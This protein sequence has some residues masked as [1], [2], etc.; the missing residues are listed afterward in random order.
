MS[1]WSLFYGAVVSNL[2]HVEDP[3]ELWEV[4]AG[5]LGDVWDLRTQPY[6][7]DADGNVYDDIHQV[8][9]CQACDQS[10]RS[11]SHALVLVDNPQQRCVAHQTHH[12]HHTRD[13]GVD[14]LDGI[15]NGRAFFTVGRKFG[16]IASWVVQRA[17]GISRLADGEEGA[18]GLLS[19]VRL[20]QPT[21][22]QDG[23]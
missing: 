14:D 5:P 23:R 10:I 2:N 17:L 16:P 18:S 21:E 3:T 19:D 6:L 4:K 1:Y 22:G 15:C 7:V 9:Q 8:P 13:E 12:E 11:I 20:S